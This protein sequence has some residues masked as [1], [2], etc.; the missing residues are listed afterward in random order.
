MVSICCEI[1]T[2]C[3]SNYNV[4]ISSVEEWLELVRYTW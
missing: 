4:D 2:P 3:S 1:I